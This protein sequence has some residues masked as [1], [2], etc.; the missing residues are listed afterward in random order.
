[1]PRPHALLWRPLGMEEVA[2]SPS[3][4]GDPGDVRLFRGKFGFCKCEEKEGCIEK[5]GLGVC[6][7]GVELPSKG[8]ADGM[9][10]GS[11]GQ[12]GWEPQK[13]G[14]GGGPGPLTGGGMVIHHPGDATSSGRCGWS[15]NLT[16]CPWHPCQ[17]V[18]QVWS[19][20]AHG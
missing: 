7:D 2:G 12:D 13:L 16:G 1:M 8:A 18:E 15:S 6:P 9:P 11:E 10:C 5:Q 17:C 20:S 4:G 19:L 3:N 14:L